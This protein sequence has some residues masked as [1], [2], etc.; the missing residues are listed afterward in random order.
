MTSKAKRRGKWMNLN[1]TLI[2]KELLKQ[3]DF[4]QER[5][6][7]YAGCTPS[8]I[9]QLVNG[10]K[11]SCSRELAEDISEA[12]NV[13]WQALFVESDSTDGRSIRKRHAGRQKPKATADEDAA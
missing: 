12:L 2:L 11:K 9:S 7:R 1:S 13:P 6:A 3:R 4:S 5:L 10:S 8:F